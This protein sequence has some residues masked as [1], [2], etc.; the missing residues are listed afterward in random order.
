MTLCSCIALAKG[1]I[2]APSAAWGS[3]KLLARVPSLKWFVVCWLQKEAIIGK[4]IVSN[5]S[6]VLKASLNHEDLVAFDPSSKL[7]LILIV[8]KQSA[9]LMSKFDPSGTPHSP[10]CIGSLLKTRVDS[11][12]QRVEHYPHV[13]VRVLQT[14]HILQR[15]ILWSCWA[16]GQMDRSS[17][18]VLRLA[19]CTYLLMTV[20][21]WVCGPIVWLGCE[22]V[23]QR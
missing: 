5:S 19:A 8:N 1:N 18:W 10:G 4:C 11:N 14:R 23:L 22:L 12:C 16:S 9:V 13:Q 6:A 21:S 20:H 15:R 7:V 2:F 17:L 3:N